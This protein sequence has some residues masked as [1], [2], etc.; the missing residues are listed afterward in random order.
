MGEIRPWKNVGKKEH[1][2]MRLFK[3]KW[4]VQHGRWVQ[5]PDGPYWG[6]RDRRSGE[7]VMHKKDEPAPTPNLTVKF[8]VGTPSL[9]VIDSKEEEE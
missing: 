5:D 3:I 6:F 4:S 1:K 2:K 8:D 9:G 7:T